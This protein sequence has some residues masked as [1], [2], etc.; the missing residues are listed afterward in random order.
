MHINA[1][2]GVGGVNLHI[3]STTD[4]QRPL[5]TKYRDNGDRDPVTNSNHEIYNTATRK[6]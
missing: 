2:C 6:E 5:G 1:G 4:Y 3:K